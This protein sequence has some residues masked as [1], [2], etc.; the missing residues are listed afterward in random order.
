[1]KK[2]LVYQKNWNKI[3]I[4]ILFSF[5]LYYMEQGYFNTIV[6]KSYA[7][8]VAMAFY[9]I[10]SIILLSCLFFY[11]DFF[12]TVKR[13]SFTL[14]DAAVF[15]FAGSCTL[16]TL[17]CPNPY[18]AFFGNRG[19]MVGLWSILGCCFIYTLLRLAPVPEGELMTPICLLTLPLFL[20]AIANGLGA[21]PFHLHEKLLASQ[22]YDFIACIG[23]I[24]AFSGYLSLLL[25][26]IYAAFLFAPRSKSLLLYAAVSF[27]GTMALFY[28]NSDGGLIGVLGA[29]ALLIAHSLRLK[30]GRRLLWLLFLLSAAGSLSE[31][32]EKTIP[33]AIPVR[34]GLPALFLQYH[35]P[36]TVMLLSLILLLLSYK[37]KY[38][39]YR[40]LLILYRIMVT[41]VVLALLLWICL[42]FT[43]SFGNNRGYIWSYGITIFARATPLQKFFGIGLE[44]FGIYT[45]RY[46]SSEIQRI[47]HS[48]LNN[49]HNE[50]LQYLVTTGIL[51]LCGY[52]SLLFSSL[53]RYMTAKKTGHGASPFLF[54]IIGYFT[55]AMINNPH[56]LLLPVLFVFLATVENT[57]S[58]RD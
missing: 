58:S 50:Y 18:E 25:P 14:T 45:E 12:F 46:F 40:P 7:L 29:L 38:S 43:P 53:Y 27:L 19:W 30:N 41:G 17:L 39:C 31:L 26:G 24:N 16:S 1:M 55:Q 11:D 3:F 47:W 10:P 51:G 49:A 5:C 44:R 34:E 8:K 48:Q 21:D 54:G 2:L 36:L 20:W 23:N 4:F 35:I 6:A 28:N 42:H 32:T 13:S 37:I 15:L 9:F 22:R 33:T 56:N 57:A 52:L